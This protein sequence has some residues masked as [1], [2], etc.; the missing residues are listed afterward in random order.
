MTIYKS[1][2]NPCGD[3]DV[4][5]SSHWPMVTM[6][7]CGRS[8]KVVHHPPRRTATWRVRNYKLKGEL[9]IGM[10][11]HLWVLG[12]FW[13][14]PFWD[15]LSWNCLISVRKL[16]AQ[17]EFPGHG[18]VG[19]LDP[20]PMEV[21]KSFASYTTQLGF[22]NVTAW[23][24]D[25]PKPKLDRVQKAVEV[26]MLHLVLI[27]HV[28]VVGLFLPATLPWTS[29]AF[30][31]HRKSKGHEALAFGP[32]VTKEVFGQG[33]FSCLRAALIL[34]QFV[35]HHRKTLG[36]CFSPVSM[37]MWWDAVMQKRPPV[38]SVLRVMVQEMQ[39]RNIDEKC[40]RAAS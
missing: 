6:G 11:K 40:G 1:Y 29:E 17:A 9:M 23:S 28:V 25:V 2:R 3:I 26:F 24:S 12:W 8:G 37:V 38:A 34:Q 27:Q 22:R 36:V 39:T 30:F 13:G 15:S 31:G 10:I 5:V 21:A 20:C 18:L 16:L 4:F 14:I 33:K 32:P 7:I 19:A 35:Y